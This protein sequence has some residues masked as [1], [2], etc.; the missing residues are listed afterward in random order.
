MTN[1]SKESFQNYLLGA[2]HYAE[3]KQTI[4]INNVVCFFEYDSIYWDNMISKTLFRLTFDDIVI[5]C[6]DFKKVADVFF[7][8]TYDY[9]LKHNVRKD[10]TK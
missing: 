9:A 1:F 8:V 6:F 7:S 3:F 2:T 4:S 10:G 5:T